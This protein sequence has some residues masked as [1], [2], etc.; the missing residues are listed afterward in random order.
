MRVVW[1]SGASSGLGKHT[2]LALKNAGWRVVAGARS[3]AGREGEG[4]Q[5]Y[6][7][8]LD[9]TDDESVAR[10]SDAA[11][12]LFGVPDALC[13][14]AGVLTL[15]AVEDVSPDEWRALL[16]TNLLGQARMIRAA[17]P[18]MRARGAGK[19]VNFSS[20][21]GLLG[22]PFQGA[23]TASKHALEGMS[24]CL[25]LE[26]RAQGIQ[27][28]LVEPGD[29]S[30]GSRAYRGHAS[31]QTPAYAE[32]YKAATARIAGDED[33]GLSP[34]RL[35]E[36]VARAMSRKRMPFRL[37]VAKFDQRLAVLLH[38]VLPPGLFARII[39]GYYK[40]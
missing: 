35:G 7:L 23:Y 16:D 5:G 8:S 28:M 33:G 32:A 34:Q 39:G 27:V 31:R 13:N 3:F 1:V 26:T 12:T 14:C 25:A 36:R 40:K 15:G 9:V 30:G 29:H 6:L 19:I 18:H 4:E 38:D 24:E 10:F 17:L 11:L 22:I 21:N 37:I 2:A 20:I